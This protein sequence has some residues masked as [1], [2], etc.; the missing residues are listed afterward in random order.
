ML[1]GMGRRVLA[2]LIL[3]A[4]VVGVLFVLR[5]PALEVQ[6]VVDLSGASRLGD[7]PLRR[8]DVTVLDEDGRYVASTEHSFPPEIYP[9]GPPVETRPVT[10][11]IRKAD[12]EVELEFQYGDTD[13]PLLRIRRLVV[14][15]KEQGILR[16]RAAGD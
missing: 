3:I 14:S 12:Y 13:P 10:L 1:G 16:L 8:L 11:S 4:C 5:S 15:V 2:Y 9:S 7:L 6:L